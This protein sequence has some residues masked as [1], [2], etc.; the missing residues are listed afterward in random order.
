MSWEEFLEQLKSEYLSKRDLLRIYN[1]FQ[2]LKKGEMSVSQYI[3]AFLEKMEL[4]P[5]LTPTE[6][7]N[8][9]KFAN[10]LHSKTT[11]YHRNNHPS[12]QMLGRHSEGENHLQRRILKEKGRMKNPQNH[13]KRIGYYNLPQMTR[14]LEKTIG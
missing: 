4:V 9:E 5:Y 8:V 1:E 11:N 3:V 10:G 6:L 2:N 14:I 13:I 7:S 12:C